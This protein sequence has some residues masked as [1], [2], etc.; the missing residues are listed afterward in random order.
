MAKANEANLL[1][2]EPYLRRDPVTGQEKLYFRKRHDIVRSPRLQ[3]YDQCM[4]E[5]LRGKRYRE[6]GAQADTEAVRQALR[7]AAQYCKA[8]DTV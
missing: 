6:H 2:L 4:S 8:H 3:A 7:Q 5:Q 1:D